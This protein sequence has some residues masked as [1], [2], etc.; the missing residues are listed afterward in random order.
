MS[1]QRSDNLAHA[2]VRGTTW[3]YIAFFSSKLVVFI[4]TVILARY[5]SRSD[6]GVVGYAVTV[7]GFLDVV[8]DLGIGASLIYHREESVMPT[9]FWL[10]IVTNTSFFLAAWFGAPL[11]GSFFNDPRAIDV[12]R[13]LA[14]N[15]PLGALGAIQETSLIKELAFNQ[16]FIPDFARAISKGILSIGLAIAGFGPWSLIVGQLGGTLV[17]VV[18]LWIMVPWRP[19]FV[20][21]GQTA[22]I[23]LRFGVPLVSMN[24]VSVFVLNVDY[25]LVGRYLGA[26]ALG[27]YTLAFRVP[28]LTILQLCNIV[29]QVIFPVFARIK[30]DKDALGKGFLQTAQYVALIT[31]PAG[32][33]MFV[34]A[35]PFVLAFFGEKWIDVI[36]VMQAI[37]I[38]TMLISLGYNAGDVYK[39]QGK[40]E[41][42]TKISVLHAFLLVPALLWAVTVSRRIIMVGVSQAI[43]AFVI[44]SIYLIVALRMLDIQ[45]ARLLNALKTPFLPAIGMSLA[46]YVV[47]QSFPTLPPWMQLILGVLTG[48]VAYL[49]LLWSLSRSVLAEVYQIAWT[50]FRG[51]L[52]D[53]KR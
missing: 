13:I 21:S 7:I 39:A 29:A 50:L 15:F 46:V 45:P 16:K 6:F 47:L 17:S 12:T 2:A 31:V 11:V 14:L 42:L 53:V 22:R 28:E 25:L 3:T 34:L 49:L 41:I 35:E 4:T 19:A 44:N 1:L 33:G 26:E 30:D 32:L 43:V 38:Y 36:P 52:A 23:L 10:N 24:I 51:R 48:L 20:F 27:I 9:A 40:P 18:I 37:S 5:L 8:K